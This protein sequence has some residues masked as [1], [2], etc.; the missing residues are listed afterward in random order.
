GRPQVSIFQGLLGPGEGSRYRC[1]F[2]GEMGHSSCTHDPYPLTGDL[3]SRRWRGQ[4]TAPQ[5]TPRATSLSPWRGLNRV[6]LG[7]PAGRRGLRRF[8]ILGRTIRISRFF[9]QAERH[10]RIARFGSQLAGTAG[11]DDD[12]LAAV[13]LI[14]R[15]GRVAPGRERVFPEKPTGLL[16]EGVDPLV[17]RAGDEY[18]AAGRHDR[19]AEGLGARSR[20]PAGGQLDVF[21]EGNPPGEFTRVEVDRVQDAPGRLDRRVPL[22]VQEIMVARESIGSISGQVARPGLGERDDVRDVVGVDV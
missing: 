5:P 2:A 13:D 15:R 10:E 19:A 3:R 11:R 12:V 18:Q 6:T 22:V 9:L 1:R 7:L 14:G 17:L 21:A 16:V 4:E 20:D 8:G